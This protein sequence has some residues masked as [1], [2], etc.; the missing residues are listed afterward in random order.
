MHAHDIVYSLASSTHYDWVEYGMIGLKATAALVAAFAS[1]AYGV[2]NAPVHA[3][4]LV[5]CN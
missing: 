2:L 4:M 5:M 1:Y 3:G